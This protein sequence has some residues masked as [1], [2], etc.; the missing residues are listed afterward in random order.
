MV[1]GYR[2]AVI[3]LNDRLS[4]LQAR[5]MELLP[6][7]VILQILLRESRPVTL[8]TR[9]NYYSMQV[10]SVCEC[11]FPT[12]F[13]I[14]PTPLEAVAPDYLGGETPRGRYHYFRYR[15]GR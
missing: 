14:Q 2:R 13:G 8:M 5:T 3:A 6:V 1:T 11:A 7:R 15:A 4:Y 12:V 10:D 9:D